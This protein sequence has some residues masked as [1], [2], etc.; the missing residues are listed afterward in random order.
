M[1]WYDVIMLIWFGWNG[2]LLGII[3]LYFMQEIARRLLGSLASW[4]FVTVVTALSSLGMLRGTL[5]ALV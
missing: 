5:P 2:L 4:V 3:S 1:N